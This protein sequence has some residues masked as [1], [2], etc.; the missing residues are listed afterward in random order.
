MKTA[1]LID[2]IIENI[3]RLVKNIRKLYST[4]KQSFKK[5]KCKRIIY[6]K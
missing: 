2:E 6:D 1:T 3:E 5:K 4:I